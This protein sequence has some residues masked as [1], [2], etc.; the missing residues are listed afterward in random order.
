M[1]E[2]RGRGLTI[3]Q[4]IDECVIEAVSIRTSNIIRI[5][6]SNDIE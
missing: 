6:L 2:E 5:A 1:R 4:S 3:I